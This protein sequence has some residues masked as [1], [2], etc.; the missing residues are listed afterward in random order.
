VIA[1]AGALT[2]VLAVGLAFEAPPH[3]AIASA[4]TIGSPS[5]AVWRRILVIGM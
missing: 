2:G 3:P 4:A 1:A 5:S